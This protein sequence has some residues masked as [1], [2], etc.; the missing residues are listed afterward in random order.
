MAKAS[1]KFSYRPAPGRLI[2]SPLERSEKTESGLYLPES[3]KE[4]PQLGKVVAYT[5]GVHDDGKPK[6]AVCEIGDTIFHSKYGG[7]EVKIDSVEFLILRED[8]VLAIQA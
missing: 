6:V 7:T 8:D 1:A 4:R 2:V 3:A 5:P